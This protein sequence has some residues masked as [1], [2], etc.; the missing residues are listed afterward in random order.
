MANRG[1]RMMAAMLETAPAGS[2]ASRK[3]SGKRRLLMMYGA[4]LDSRKAALTAHLNAGGHVAMWDLAYFERD[5]AMRL[6]IDSLHPTKTQLDMAPDTARYAHDLRMHANPDG[7]ILLVGIGPKSCLLY[8]LKP[9][10]WENMKLAELRTRFPKREI[11]WRPKGR[12]ATPF[13]GLRMRHGMPIQEA[14]VGCSLVVCRHSN[15]AVDAVI[16][17]I[18]VEC[19][20]GAALALYRDNPAPNAVQR[21]DFLRKLGWWNWKPSEAGQAWEWIWKVVA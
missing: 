10:E 12:A 3:Y 8:G 4:G 13:S 1:K 15:C 5:E 17:G 2:V 6:S 21:S 16:A 19:E 9:L 18:P 20:D 11:L 7:P 14:L